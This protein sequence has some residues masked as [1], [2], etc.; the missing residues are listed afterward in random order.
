M[1]MNATHETTRHTFLQTCA[2]GVSAVRSGIAFPSQSDSSMIT[3]SLTPIL[4]PEPDPKNRE[5]MTP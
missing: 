2:A 1:K 4:R 3:S 5:A